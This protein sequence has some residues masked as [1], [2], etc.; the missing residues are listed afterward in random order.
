MHAALAPFAGHM[1]FLTA[2]GHSR[3]NKATGHVIAKAASKIGINKSAH[4]LRKF[5]ATALADAGAG[6]ERIAA[7]TG[8]RSLREVEH[9]TETADRRR[10]VMG[11]EQGQ[12]LGNQSDQ[13]CKLIMK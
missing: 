7:W 6:P 5:R 10:A 3:S 4:G 12:N 11:T 13:N 2:H 8:H 1:T 9:Y